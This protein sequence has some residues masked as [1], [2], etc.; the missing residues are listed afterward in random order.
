MAGE[1]TA[2]EAEFDTGGTF[3]VIRGYDAAH[4]LFRGRRTEAYTQMTASDIAQKVAQRAGLPAGDVTSTTTVFEHV[5]QAGTSDWDLL[6]RLAADVGVRHH[7]AGGQ[8]RLRTAYRGDRRPAAGGAESPDPLVLRLG[9]DLLRFRAVVTSAEQVKE[10]EVR[11]WDTATKQALMSTEPAT[12]TTVTLPD[13]DPAKLAIEYRTAKNIKS[14]DFLESNF[15]MMLL[16][17]L[18]MFA[19]TITSYRETLYLT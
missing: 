16:H 14:D 8:V 15:F 2:L 7:R 6:Q 5:S 1:V 13:I 10:V 3:T 11:G 17:P 9:S 19:G 18:P 12:T 4:R